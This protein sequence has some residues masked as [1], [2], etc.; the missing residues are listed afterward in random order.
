MMTILLHL[1]IS[2]AE[3]THSNGIFNV[4]D[5][6]IS[7]YKTSVSYKKL[8]KFFIN[9][10]LIPNSNAYTER[11]F[12]MVKHTKTDLRNLLEVTTVSTM[13]QI[14]TYYEENEIL[15]VDEDNMFCYNHAIKDIEK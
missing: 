8:A 11:V 7:L 12:S 2:P 6:W 10:M 14:K 1:P 9:L 13:M 5:Y 4:E 15:Q 3:Q